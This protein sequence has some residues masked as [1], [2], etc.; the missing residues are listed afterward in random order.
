MYAKIY[1]GGAEG[2][3]FVDDGKSLLSDAQAFIKSSGIQYF[4][5]RPQLAEINIDRIGVEKIQRA[6]GIVDLIKLG[7]E[8]IIEDHN[9]WKLY[10]VRIDSVTK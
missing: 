10:K 8:L 3:W 9:G 5:T 4:V 6:Y 7:A 2:D 1:N